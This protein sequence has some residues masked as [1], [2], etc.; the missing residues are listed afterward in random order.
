M[1]SSANDTALQGDV[2]ICST[3]H[4]KKISKLSENT[5]NTQKARLSYKKPKI[6]EFLLIDLAFKVD[7]WSVASHCFIFRVATS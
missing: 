5:N 2:S 3:L 4:W 7:N 6:F 1:I